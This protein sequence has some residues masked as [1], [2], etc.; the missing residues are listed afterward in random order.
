MTQSR[1]AQ[2]L[3]EET[4][5][6]RRRPTV[7]LRRRRRVSTIVFRRALR[8][9]LWV[10]PVV[11]LLWWSL[12]ASEFSIRSIEIN[13]DDGPSRGWVASQLAQFADKNLVRLELDEVRKTLLRHPWVSEVRI[14]KDLPDRLS[15]TVFEHLPRGVLMVDQEEFLVAADGLV[16]SQRESAEERLSELSDSDQSAGSSNHSSELAGEDPLLEIRFSTPPDAR[17][18][19]WIGRRLPRVAS[20]FRTL[21]EVMA[22]STSLV[23]MP[24][25]ARVLGG[26]DF[27]FEFD[28]GAPGILISAAS[29]SERARLLERLRPQIDGRYRVAAFD[30]R[31]GDRIVLRGAELIEEEPNELESGEAARLSTSTSAIPTATVRSAEAT[32]A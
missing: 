22:G 8:V 26:G 2:I 9:A 29:A 18:D 16:F 5:P 14:R 4:P 6:F 23:R 31:F 13:G 32:G 17:V 28:A 20:L 25:A 19:Q 11:A 10:V 27:E 24:V 21:D 7:P 30:L 15:V 3:A 1:L 12:T